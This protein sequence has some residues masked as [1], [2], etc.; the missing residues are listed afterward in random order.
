MAFLRGGGALCG[1]AS[2]GMDTGYAGGDCPLSWPRDARGFACHGHRPSLGLG[3]VCG[4]VCHACRALDGASGLGSGPKANH[5]ILYRLGQR[6]G[7]AG[8]VPIDRGCA[9]HPP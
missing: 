3:M 6:L 2:A 9:A 7:A 8:A 5:Q 1:R 4:H